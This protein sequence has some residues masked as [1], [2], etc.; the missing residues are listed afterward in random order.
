MQKIPF[1]VIVGEKEVE[2]G[3]IAVRRHGGEDLGSLSIGDFSDL[4][5]ME[6]NSTLKS[7]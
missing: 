4:I 2:E 5:S 1:M 7:F 3:T 6:I